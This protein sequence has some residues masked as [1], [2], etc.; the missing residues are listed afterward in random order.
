MLARVAAT[1]NLLWDTTLSGVVTT[2]YWA[3]FLMEEVICRTSNF[4]DSH[5]LFGN[6]NLS[7]A[8]FFAWSDFPL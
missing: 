2:F 4:Y 8:S 6:H 7:E 3:V 5:N 1:R